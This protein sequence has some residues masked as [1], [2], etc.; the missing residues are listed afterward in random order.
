MEIFVLLPLEKFNLV[1]VKPDE[2]KKKEEERMRYRLIHSFA[3][4]LQAFAILTCVIGKRHRQIAP[5]S[6]VVWMV[7]AAYRTYGARRG[8]VTPSN[9]IRGKRCVPQL[10][11]VHTGKMSGTIRWGAER[12]CGH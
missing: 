9:S 6:F 2:S 1:Q 8:F 12:M 5:R 4:W 7:G 11:Y 3:N 10:G